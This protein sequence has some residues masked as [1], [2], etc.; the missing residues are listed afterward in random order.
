MTEEVG[1]KAIAFVRIT[2]CYPTIKTQ[3]ILQEWESNEAMAVELVSL[4]DNL[5]F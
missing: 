3:N 5:H 2:L 4:E 1:K